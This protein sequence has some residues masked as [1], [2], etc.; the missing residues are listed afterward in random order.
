M[1]IQ[2]QVSTADLAAAGEGVIVLGVHEGALAKQKNFAALDQL[3]DGA[4]TGQ[5][6]HVDYAG[7]ARRM[8]EVPT[9]GRITARK[10]LVVGLGPKR[11]LDAARVRSCVATATRIAGN[12]PAI[13]LSLPEGIAGDL[14][15][16]VAEG[17]EL[18][19]YRFV[20]YLTGERLPKTQLTSAT[21][22]R[23][24]K[25]T[26]TESKALAL[27][28]DVAAAVCIARDA[29]N[30]PPNELTPVELANRAQQVAR[31]GGLKISVLNK[32]QIK[33]AGMKLHY[34]VGQGSA[35]EP[36][37]VHMTHA[38]AKAK[39]RIVF[40]GKGLTFDSGGLCIKPAAGM[41]EMKSDMGGAAA[42]LG[43]MAA[44]AAVKP[45]VE[46]HGI[47]SAAEN[48][49]DGAAYRPGDVFG[50]LDGKTVEIVN[51]DAEGRLVLADALAYARQLEPDLI[52]EAST[53]TGACVVAL[54]KL[55]SAFYST[56]EKFARHFQDS[57]TAAGELFWRMPLAAELRDQLKSDIADL[58]HTGER[59]GGS[60]TAALFLKEFVGEVP[61][62]HCDV[63][64]AVLAD[65]PRGMY[66]KGGTGH[67]VL[68][69]LRFLEA[70]K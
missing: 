53:L 24:K 58:K 68:T 51:T 31:K 69:F 25:L 54:G 45:Q 35:N 26:P 50:S 30:E 8:L 60:I 34:A 49:P 63:A 7:S 19:A 28:L 2:V 57:A 18:G 6:S 59:W 10:V 37:F 13:A 66:P 11:G 36:R 55:Y 43:L 4:L 16:A 62:I 70:L 1:A 9:L 29:V 5:A 64:G 65:R 46:V 32:A 23:S 20:K 67:P 56:D 39:R 41:G 14:L 47:I 42:V 48:M 40:V 27:G 17:V 15:R 44:V 52:I 12:V 21:V 22:Y 38:P 61:F 33:K 3:L